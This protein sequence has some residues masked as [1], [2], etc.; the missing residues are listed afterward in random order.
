MTQEILVHAQGLLFDMDGVLVSST[1]GVERCWRRWAAHYGLPEAE[2]LTIEHGQRAIDLVRKLKPDID[3]EEG[4]RLIEDMEL[5]DVADLMTLPGADALLR[6]LPPGRWAVVT[7]A[8]DRLLVGRLEVAGLPMP[9]L[10]ISAD[11]V[12][13]G[14]P[15]PEPYRRG[16]ELIGAAAAECV[17]VEDAPKGVQAGKGAG[18]RVLG[19][20][21]TYGADELRAAGADWIVG[22]LENVTATATESGLELR[23]QVVA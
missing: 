23:L 17:V 5:E 8:T 15:D 14:K 12:V 20:V 3:A 21:G 1:G 18:C 6:S 9:E 2:T 13:K 4:L 7:S 16:A 22:S 11:R 19:M 10:F